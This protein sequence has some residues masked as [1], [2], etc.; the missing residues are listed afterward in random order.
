MTEP[1]PQD[2]P[3]W[4]D[5]KLGSMA[6]SAL[7]LLHEVGEGNFFTKEQLHAAFPDV[8][9]ID[10]RL[11][12]LRDHG[13]VIH[14]SRDD[15][16]LERTDQ[17]LVKQGTSVWDPVARKRQAA[18][19]RNARRAVLERD[20]FACRYCG[21]SAGEGAATPS[22]L[23]VVHLVPLAEGGK[24]DLDNLVVLCSDCNRRGVLR[25]GMP[26][27]PDVEKLTVEVAALSVRERT[28][29]LAWMTMGER[30]RTAIEEIWAQ[31]LLLPSH[32][33]Q[34]MAKQLARL[35]SEDTQTEDSE[36]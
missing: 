31:Y 12:D 20:G 3:D 17:R 8:A 29:L 21:H 33:R 22:A 36:S 2:L 19:A 4:R 7:W 35:L 24:D 27:G 25:H 26:A 6:R 18:V 11:R 23:S 14:T 28:Q 13:W 15:P 30:P 16:T 1:D 9:Q 32:H 34:Q 5:P 10:R